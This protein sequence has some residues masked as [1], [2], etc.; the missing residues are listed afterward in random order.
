MDPR[1]RVKL[2]QYDNEEDMEYD[3]DRNDEQQDMQFREQNTELFDERQLREMIFQLENN[4]KLNSDLRMRY[5]N[6]PDKFIDSEV[7][8]D[9][10]LRK[11]LIL[12]AYPQLYP[13]FYSSSAVPIVIQLLLHN[14][15]SISNDVIQFLKELVAPEND[16]EPKIIIQL[17]DCLIRNYL[18]ESLGELIGKNEEKSQEEV[19][20][21]HDCFEVIENMVDIKSSISKEIGLRSKI[22][23]YLVKRVE[24]NSQNLDDNRLYASELLVELTQQTKENLEIIGRSGGIES[25]LMVL[26]QYRKKDPETAEEKEIL[27]NVYDLLTLLLIQE[28]NQD[29]FQSYEGLQ[30]MIKII[31]GKTSQSIRAYSLMLLAINNHKENCQKLIQIGGLSIIFPI[32]ERKG[33]KH[34]DKNKQFEIDETTVQIIKQLLRRN[35]DATFKQ[36]VFDKCVEKLESLRKLRKEYVEVI[37]LIDPEEYDDLDEKQLEKIY[38]DLLGKGLIVIE[39]IDVILLELIYK[40]LDV[41]IDQQEIVS[42]VKQM[43]KYTGEKEDIDYYNP[44]LQKFQVNLQ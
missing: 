17:Y 34:K 8:L 33:L 4:Y 6:Q 42:S 43:L 2:Q 19:N 31:Q 30:L 27:N 3:D 44:L 7:D 26:N 24:D 35:T 16:V 13:I 25:L 40:D 39:S 22:I 18:I 14:N 12:P 23:Q 37:P 21:L 20:L 38:F 1:K 15:Q 9:E 41:Q 11:L 36:R 28:E 29:Y 5:P 10:D 32:L